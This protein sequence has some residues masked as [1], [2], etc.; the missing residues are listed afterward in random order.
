MHTLHADSSRNVEG[1]AGHIDVPCNGRRLC[2]G[3]WAIFDAYQGT[4]VAPACAAAWA[5]AAAPLV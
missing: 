4:T 5:A 3:S 2:T 1:S